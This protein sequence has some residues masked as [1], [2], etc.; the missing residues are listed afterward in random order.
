MPTLTSLP[1]ISNQVTDS[2]IGP[3]SACSSPPSSS[4]EAVASA[5]ASALGGRGRLAVGG[6]E[7][8]ALGLLDDL[9]A[10]LLG[11][12]IV[13]GVG[14]VA[15]PGRVGDQRQGE[16]DAHGRDADLGA[17]VGQPLA[18]EQDDE[19][20]SRREQRDDPRVVEHRYPFMV[21]T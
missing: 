1:P 18:E 4:A 13:L 21:S 17:L 20:R 5:V 16:R 2:V 14:D 11:L 10:V 8:V 15:E 9:A 3:T 19:E 12:G 6:R 7:G